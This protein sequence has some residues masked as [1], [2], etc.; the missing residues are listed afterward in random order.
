MDDQ[1]FTLQTYTPNSDLATGFKPSQI[2]W[3]RTGNDTL[4]GLQPLTPNPGQ[5]QID[6]FIGDVA[7]DDPALRQWSDT[8]VLGDWTRPY[9]A[10]GN[11]N[12]FGL[13]DFGFIVDFNSQL[14]TAQLHGTA[15]DYQLLDV[16]VGSALF[17]QQETGLDAI[18]FLLGASNLSLEDSYFQFQ[19]STPP[20]GPVAPQ[21]KQLGSKGFDIAAVTATDSLGKVYIAGGTTGS[22]GGDNNG[23]SRDPLVARYDSDGNQELILQ[24]G[25][26]NFDTIY[27]LKADKEGNFYVAGTTEGDLGATKQSIVA[28][29]WVAKYDKEGNQQ[30]IQQFEDAFISS[31][32]SLDIDENSNVYLSGITVRQ[33]EPDFVTDDFWVTKYDT[34]GNRQWFTEFGSSAFDE[35]YS[36]TVSTDGSV[37]AGGWSLGDFAG[38]NANVGLYDAALAK[39]NNQGEVE[40]TRQFG[41]SDYEWTWGVDTDSQGNLYATGWTLGDL[42]GENAGSYDA[43]LT[44]FDSLGNQKWIKQF[45]SSGDDQAF[46]IHIDAFDNIFLTGYTNSNLGGANAGSFDSWVAKYDV[47]GD[48]SWLQQFGSSG[49]EQAY[50]ITSDNAGTLF[51]TGTTDGS[52]GG[53][54]TGSFDIWVAK[55]DAAFGTLQDF[56]GTPSPINNFLAQNV[57]AQN[58]DDY[59]FTTQEVSYISTFFEEFVAS[60]GVESDGSGLIEL[61]SNPYP[62]VPPPPVTVPEPSAGVSLLML[63]AVSCVG[64]MLKS[65]LKKSERLAHT[66]F[67]K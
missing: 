14:D 63:A 20:P 38:P 29:A 51:V 60:L 1:I 15:S 43:W 49:F 45:G 4:L 59:Q 11:P 34:D 27:G 23:D 3:G 46:D 12:P 32:F 21:I 26:S 18:G 40:W 67:I 13:N 47:D 50:S 5:V 56:N 36:V 62:S 28:D 39:L 35:P 9:Y 22:L 19:G 54:N 37:Y 17:S 2:I 41:T 8:F 10:N 66:N 57:V 16:G 42:A 31:A 55:L 52:L 65:R 25:T 24:F 33:S 53:V 64:A 6:L 48:Q 7:I 61:I 30:W 44:K 58:T